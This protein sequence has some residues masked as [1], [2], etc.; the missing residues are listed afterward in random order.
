MTLDP[1]SPQSEWLSSRTPPTTN[2][3]DA[4]R[5]EPSYTVGENAN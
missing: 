5:K 3:E 2:G 4:R 1:I